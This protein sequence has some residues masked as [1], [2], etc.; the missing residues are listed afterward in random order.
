MKQYVFMYVAMY[1]KS[2]QKENLVYNSDI[3]YNVILH[4]PLV[5]HTLR[6]HVYISNKA[7]LLV[8]Y[9]YIIL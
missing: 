7:L 1:H 9:V 5:L 4:L 6:D 3:Y 2:D 8:L